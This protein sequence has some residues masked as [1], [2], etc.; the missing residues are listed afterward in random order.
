MDGIKVSVIVPVYNV[1]KYLPKCIESIL[2]Q[3]HENLEII[4]VNDGSTDE[5]GLICESY[6]E[7]DTRIVVI[8]E[9]NSGVSNARNTGISK[10]TGEWIC[11]VDGDDYI[12]PDY[13][14]YMLKNAIQYEADVSLTM[15]MFGNF[16]KDQI[17]KDCIKIWNSEDAVEAILCYQVP[18]GC[19]CKLFNAKL[20]TKIRFIPE[21]FI[22][23]GFNFNIDAFQNSEKI[24]AGKRKTYYYRR[25]NPTSAMTKFSIEKCECGLWA[26]EVIKNN[27]TIQTD[28]IEAAWKYA[29]WRTH[30]DFY[31]MCVLANVKK[32]YPKMYKKCLNM[33][34]KMALIALR[35]PTSKQ[36]KMRAIIMRICPGVIP[37][38]MK[39]RKFRYHVNVNNR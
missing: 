37:F 29:N 39:A 11:F 16:N 9:K 32:E 1:R 35:V 17:K 18:I 14:E 12:M 21:I 19:Y 3:T 28:R 4:L 23:E 5:S 15:Q 30:S 6:A 20:L 13:V 25:D 26:L 31:D 24:V 36:N 8:H 7:R 27:L 34:R 33:T 2:Y 10:A 38:A 22:G